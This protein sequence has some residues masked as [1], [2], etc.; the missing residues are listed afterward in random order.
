LDPGF[1]VDDAENL[2]NTLAAKGDLELAEL[3]LTLQAFASE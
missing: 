3:A 2:M 1:D